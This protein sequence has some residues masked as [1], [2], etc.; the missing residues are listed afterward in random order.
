LTVYILEDNQSVKALRLGA[1]LEHGETFQIV[2]PAGRWFGATV[3]EPGN[4]AL[5]GCTVAPG[6]H[7]DDFELAKREDLL[8]QYPYHEALIERLTVKPR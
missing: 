3:N 4:Y 1:D 5:V 2:V 8:R 7:F 6:F